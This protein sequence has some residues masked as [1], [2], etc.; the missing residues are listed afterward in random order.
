LLAAARLALTPTPTPLPAAPPLEAGVAGGRRDLGVFKVTGYSDSPYLNGTDGRGITRSG[1]LT[2]WGAVAVDPGIIP[3]GTRLVI[4][5]Y[6]GT[7][8]TA[9][10]TGGGIKG[11]WIDIW[12]PTD[13]EALEHGLKELA[14][15]IIEGE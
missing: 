2:H 12:F 13:G 3:L 15:A 6:E 5:N 14:I 1:V 11:R 4:E 10:D 9:L 8:F 7:I